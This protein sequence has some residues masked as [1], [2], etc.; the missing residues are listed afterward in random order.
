MADA[1]N[2]GQY[3]ADGPEEMLITQKRGG[4][5]SSECI[6]GCNTFA[7]GVYGA[8]G[9]VGVTNKRTTTRNTV[10]ERASTL[11]RFE[12]VPNGKQTTSDEGTQG[13]GQA[14]P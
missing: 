6:S 1:A 5:P 4:I 12:K 13:Q 7:Y 10:A 3:G 11:K 8:G 9:G 2:K 14:T